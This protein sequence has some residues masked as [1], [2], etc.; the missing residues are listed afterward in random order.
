MLLFHVDWF[1]LALF[2]LHK[3]VPQMIEPETLRK[4][5]RYEPA[6]G[7]LF[8]RDRPPEMFNSSKNCSADAVARG[9][10][11]QHAGKEAF[12]STTCFGYRQGS[13]L[14]KR[15]DA[16]RLIWA[17]HYGEWPKGHIDHVNGIR[18]DNRIANLRDVS[19]TDNQRNMKRPITNKSGVMGV[20]V[21]TPTGAWRAQ[22]M[23]NRKNVHIGVFTDFNDAV[24]ARK[25]AEV[26]YGFHD[27]HGR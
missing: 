2:E 4:L 6:T 7:K 22:I 15:H 17:L 18:D 8:W 19:R 27:N 26:A 20:Y 21:H 16:H 13:I 24:A 11:T 12:T 9:W 14:C 23:V 1:N 3:E 10:N 5:L 25:A